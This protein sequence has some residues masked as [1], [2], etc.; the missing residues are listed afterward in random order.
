M[1]PSSSPLPP[2]P[3]FSSLPLQA[4]GPRG[5]AWG[6]H[7]PTDQLGCLNRLTPENTIEAA[8]EIKYGFR[9]STDWA[10]DKPKVPCF[11]R[12]QFEQKI[13]HKSPRTVNDD[14][15]V[16]NTQSSSQWDGFRHFVWVE[17]GGIV[18]RGVL[19]DYAYWAESQG[20]TVNPLTTI[21]IPLSEIKAVAEAQNVTF[22]PGDIL[23]IRTGY[24]R[25]FE[26]LS[27]SEAA[28]LATASQ[29]TA[30]GLE[31]CPEVLEW[32]WSHE[33]SAAAGDQPALE[34][35]PFDLTNQYWMH[36]W[37]LAGWGMPIGELFDLERLGEECRKLKK[38]TFFFSS[39]PLKVPGG[40]A[41]PPNGVAIL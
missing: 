1:S 3:L 23:F 24:L 16:L 26:A 11:G 33:F 37:L 2:T 10:L 38:W 18:G 19:L 35:L 4:S 5:N 22:R 36:E 8:K 25:A 9:I 41:S 12:V 13:I 39:V 32:L 20:H 17:N 28:T 27:S 34:S 21:K 40:V 30:I 7:G 6:L 14:V 31:A 29:M 15:L